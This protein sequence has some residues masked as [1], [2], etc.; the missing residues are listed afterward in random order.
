MLIMAF[1]RGETED[2]FKIDEEK[3]KTAGMTQYDQTT[4]Y[5]TLYCTK[6]GYTKE[7]TSREHNKIKKI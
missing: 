4:A 6:C 1:V 3:T 7:V 5:S 2:F